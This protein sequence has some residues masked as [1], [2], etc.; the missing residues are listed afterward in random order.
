VSEPVNSFSVSDEW[1]VELRK[2][3]LRND[4]GK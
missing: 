3:N 1:H 4:I 2:P